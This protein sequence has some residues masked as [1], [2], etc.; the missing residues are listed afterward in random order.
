MTAP[1]PLVVGL[2]ID[3]ATVALDTAG[4]NY[5][6]EYRQ[7]TDAPSG[8][9]IGVDPK[10]GTQVPL[11]YE[12]LLVVATAPPTTAPSPTEEEPSPAASAS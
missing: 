2:P 12:V 1:I 11:G 3:Q 6:L 9:V 7:T 8:T 5:R 10:V 4:L